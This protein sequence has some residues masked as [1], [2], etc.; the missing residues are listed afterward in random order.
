MDVSVCDGPADQR[1]GEIRSVTTRRAVLAALLLVG[2]GESEP[3]AA[4]QSG[5]M[6]PAIVD[7]AARPPTIP[8]LREW[9][10][11]TGRFELQ[12]GS[13]IRVETADMR[14]QRVAELLAD[15]LGRMTARGIAVAPGG[16]AAG[17]GDIRLTLNAA[18]SQLGREGYRLTISDSVSVRAMDAA[19]AFYGTRT[20]L[21]M[22]Q[23]GGGSAP[24]GDAR[25]WPR[26]P[27]RGLML[28][29][30]RQHLTPAWI[31]ARI[32]EMAWLKLNYLHLH[33]SDDLGFRIES[34][35]HPEIVSAEH[36]T[37]NELDRLLDVA[38][39][40]H[41]T[42]VPEIGMPAH[43]GAAL[44]PH[45]EFQLV[46]IFGRRST[47]RLDITN[48]AALAFARQL[49]DEFIDIFPSAYWHTGADEYMR[50]DEYPLHPQLQEH[51]R[52]EYGANAS[53]KDAV[54]GFV[55]WVDG[56][57]RLRGK[58][59]RMWHDDL[60]GGVAVTVNPAIVVEWW[61]DVSPLSDS[62]PPPPQRLLDQG[63]R[64]FNAGF[65][66]TYYASWIPEP[67]F[68]RPDMRAAYESWLVHEFY[69]PMVVGGPLR[70]PPSTVDP[71]EPRNLGSKLHVWNDIPGSETEAQIAVGI[72]PRLRVLAQ[73]TWE[74]PPLVDSYDDFLKVI[75][76]VGDPP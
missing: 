49:I 60:N 2:C 47:N 22:L 74:S 65:F 25:D 21:Q 69:G 12:D 39:R 13:H 68:L 4:S 1:V 20:L 64:I 34:R 44:A 42:V 73:K 54:H 35:S 61:T 15:D 70:T 56:L 58:T 26:Y 37:L 3:P 17:A 53:A 30:G 62:R 23:A 46:D 48:P 71:A 6:P 24:A 45:P 19:G 41:V 32:R 18:D 16:H 40:H 66:P 36:I 51:A 38:E 7:L 14:L 72:R 29:I 63:H 76:T 50:P 55:N 8:A 67:L 5:E 52:R 43:M 28:D 75:D 33:L 31:E 27:E 11:A 57:V 59:T 9:A 10:P